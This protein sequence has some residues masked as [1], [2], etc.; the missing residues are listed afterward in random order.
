LAQH[1]HHQYTF[2]VQEIEANPNIDPCLIEFEHFQFSHQHLATWLLSYWGFCPEVLTIIQWHHSLRCPLPYASYPHCTYL[3]RYYLTP[4]GWGDEYKLVED[5]QT[6]GLT[7]Q[8]HHLVEQE[9][10][11]ITQLY[12]SKVGQNISLNK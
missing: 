6:L 8:E 10:L 1:F 3:A 2:I 5:L 11:R 4:L 7:T 12:Q 9:A